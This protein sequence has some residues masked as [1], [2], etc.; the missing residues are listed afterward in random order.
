MDI[1]TL[2]L[3][4]LGLAMDA[5]AVSISTGIILKKISFRQFFRLSF[6]FGLFQA[7]MPI[8]G[9]L[10]G[11][12]VEKH[13]KTYDHWIAFILLA[14]IGGKMIYEAFREEEE[15]IKNDPTRGM[16]LVI[17]SIATSI[18]AMAVG[19]SLA[20]LK[21]S[22]WLPSIIIGIITLCMS[23]LGMNIGKFVGVLFGKRVSIAGGIILLIIGIKILIGHLT[24]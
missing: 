19:F 18:D 6:H 5:F 3:I 22:I 10:A 12:T 9:W 13:I 4:A 20:V 14:F 16:S 11:L 8:I 21:V 15:E 2:L 23:V 24:E 7:F 17:L 1:I